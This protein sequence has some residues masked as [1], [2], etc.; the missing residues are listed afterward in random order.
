MK[1]IMEILAQL[2]ILLTISQLVKKLIIYCV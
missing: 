2:I 1:A